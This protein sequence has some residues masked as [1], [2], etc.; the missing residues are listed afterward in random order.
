MVRN[1]HSS[2]A[3]FTLVELLVALFISA[4]IGVASVTFLHQALVSRDRIDDHTAAVQALQMAHSLVKDDMLQLVDRP[5]RGPYGSNRAAFAGGITHSN[6]VFLAFTRGLS[7]PIAS[8]ARPALEYVRYRFEAGQL[9]READARLDPTGKTVPNRQILLTGLKAVDIRFLVKDQWVSHFDNSDGSGS[10]PAAI[11]LTL[12]G[13]KVGTLEQL[14]MI[15]T[16]AT[17]AEPAS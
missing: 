6:S 14:F 3:G 8:G 13:S 15:H 16:G 7:G 4:L 2:D 10:T 5:T 11:A 12:I 9:I 1:A 17:K